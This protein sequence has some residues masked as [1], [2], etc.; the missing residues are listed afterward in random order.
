MTQRVLIGTSGW[1][2]DHW[3]GIFYPPELEREGWLAFYAR[4]FPTVEINSS[5]YRLPFENMVLGWHRRTPEDFVFAAKFSRQATHVQR[6]HDCHT[7]VQRWM[8]RLRLLEEKLGVILVQLPPGL[9]RDVPLLEGFLRLFPEDVRL[10]VEFRHASWEC[11]EVYDM[12]RALGVAHCTISYPRYPVNWTVTAPFAYVRL[13]GVTQAYDY[14]YSTEE[15]HDLATHIRELLQKVQQVF[16][17][18]NN[19]TNGYAPDNARQL[20]TILALEQEVAGT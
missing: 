9:H 16:V 11:D 2:Y 17:Y 12:L 18:F 14:C 10:A 5:F 4:A 1:S 8:E 7:I 6:L 13:H 19:D 20:Q 3:Q 15:L